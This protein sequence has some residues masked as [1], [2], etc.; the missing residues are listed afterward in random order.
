MKSFKYLSTVLAG[1]VLFIACQ[2]ELSVESGFAGKVAV[3]SLLDSANN[4]QNIAIN[5]TYTVDGTLTSDN[6]VTLHVNLTEGGRYTIFTD[7]QNG[8]SFQDSGFLAAGPQTVRLKAAGRPI[9]AKPTIFTVSFDTSF[10]SFTINVIGN[11]PA[12]FSLAGAPGTCSAA[13]VQGTYATGTALTAANT[14]AL[15]V[16]V[17]SL[18][19]YNITTTPVGGMTF[20]GSGNFTTLGA[21]TITLQGSGTPTTAGANS[22]PVTAGTSNCSFNVT[23][24]TGTNNNTAD[25][26]SDTAWTF[27]A[28]GKTYHGP[29]YDVFDS[30]I[31]GA[32][33]I[34]FLGFTPLRA[35][36]T[37]QFGAFSTTG[38]FPPSTVYSSKSGLAAFYFTD[39]ATDTSG[40]DIYTANPPSAASPTPAEDVTLTISAYNATSGFVSGIFSGTALN[41]AG[42]PVQITNGRFRAMIR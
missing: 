17:T 6:Y 28:G 18:G 3:G 16:N 35:D 20:S 27:T 34:I 31:N 14:V 42:T 26:S 5:G 38:T 32:K 19:S 13:N 1:L 22:V 10:C 21:Q 7:T 36:T 30:T 33:G 11:T 24:T 9:L 15:Q 8:F 40:V 37:I 23:V 4:C 2:K 12:V 29:F 41:A 25:N 39:Y